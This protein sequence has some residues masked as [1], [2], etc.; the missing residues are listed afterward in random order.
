LLC[1][2]TVVTSET[3]KGRVRWVRH[4]ERMTEETTVKKVFKDIPEGKKTH[5]K[6]KKEAVGRC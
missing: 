5:W 4:V 6:A 2:E 1:G 3:M